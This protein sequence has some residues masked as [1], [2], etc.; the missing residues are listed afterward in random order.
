MTHKALIYLQVWDSK[1]QGIF[2]SNCC[3]FLVSRKYISNNFPFFRCMAQ[4]QEH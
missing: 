2:F 1:Q 3:I 4:G